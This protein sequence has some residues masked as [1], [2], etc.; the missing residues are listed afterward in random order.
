M[1]HDDRSTPCRR[2]SRDPIRADRIRRIDGG[3]VFVPHRFLRDG[4]YAAL[5]S[6]EAALYLLLVLVG[7]KSG[8]SYYGYDSLSSLLQIDLDR[9]ADARDGLID[10]DLIAFDGTRFQVLSLP[11]HPLRAPARRQ[12]RDASGSERSAIRRS[13]REALQRGGSRNDDADR[14]K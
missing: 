7:D 12:I 5:T 3:F 8:V 11:N 2:I 4:F 10:Q 14:R 6:D 13:I 1:T 9:Y